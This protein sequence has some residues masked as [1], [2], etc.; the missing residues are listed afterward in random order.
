MSTVE[1]AENKQNGQLSLL[2]C[3]PGGLVS[4]PRSPLVHFSSGILAGCLAGVVTQPADVV[5]THMQLY[6]DKFQ[7]L[8]TTA[9]YIY[10]VGVRLSLESGSDFSEGAV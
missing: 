9:L 7:R 4:E 5:K 2:C 1:A 10:R 6:P 8:H 3:S